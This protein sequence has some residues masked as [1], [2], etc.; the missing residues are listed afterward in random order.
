MHT[1]LFNSEVSLW[2]LPLNGSLKIKKKMKYGKA[3]TI[4]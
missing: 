2:N 4:V 1:K 3:F